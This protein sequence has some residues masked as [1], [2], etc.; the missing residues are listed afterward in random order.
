MDIEHFLTLSYVLEEQEMAY[1]IVLAFQAR[2][3][4]EDKPD[5][6]MFNYINS[7]LEYFFQE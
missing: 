2:K 6:K 3:N 5:L 4:L 1:M 7:L